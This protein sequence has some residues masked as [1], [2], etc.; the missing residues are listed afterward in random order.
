MDESTK[1]SKI[2]H[3]LNI[4]TQNKIA[5]KEWRRRR[6]KKKRFHINLVQNTLFFSFVRFF[7]PLGFLGS[8]GE[9]LF[10]IAQDLAILSLSLS[11][12]CQ[13]PLIHVHVGK[14]RGYSYKIFPHNQ[15]KSPKK[16]LKLK[17]G[18]HTECYKT[19]RRLN[20]IKLD[21]F[22]QFIVLPIEEVDQLST[23]YL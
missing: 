16:R 11:P 6:K 9:L 17:C 20:K 3:V 12:S 4:M 10:N 22:S 2:R 19:W 21:S 13:V 15:A 18:D 14:S 1:W 8:I 23:C 5:N 7:L